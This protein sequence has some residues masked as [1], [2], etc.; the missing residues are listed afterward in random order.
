MVNMLQRLTCLAVSNNIWF[1]NTCCRA[2]LPTLWGD[3]GGAKFA[4]TLTSPMFRQTESWPISSQGSRRQPM[5]VYKN[6]GAEGG[7]YL[8]KSSGFTYFLLGF[9]ITPISVNISTWEQ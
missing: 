3:G 1:C 6:Y 7:R 2:S 9:V 8:Y 4:G 5:Y